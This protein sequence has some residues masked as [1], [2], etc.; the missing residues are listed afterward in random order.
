M[1]NF[2]RAF[3]MIVGEEGVYS[4]DPEDN[5][6]WTGGKK[7]YG[8][9]KGTKYGISAKTYPRLDIENLSLDQAKEIAKNDY[10]DKIKGDQLPFT[11]GLLMFDSA[12][13]QG[14][15]TAIRLAQDAC[16]VLVD[17]V[18][19][20][21]TLAALQSG[22]DRRPARFMALRALRYLKDPTW[23]HHGYG[24]YTRLFAMAL[25]AH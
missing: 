10:W 4:N 2:D 23:Q 9:L 7:G 24:W 11:W 20:P 15:T 18:L 6:N 14:P 13:N 22:D 3:K 1:T 19:G 8:L 17:G 25:S 21:R 5:G 16:G 12:Y